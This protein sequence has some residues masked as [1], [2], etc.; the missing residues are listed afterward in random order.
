VGGV[1]AKK[2]DN[3]KVRFF[4]IFPPA[5]TSFQGQVGIVYRGKEDVMW[6]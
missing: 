1:G 6:E 5:A 4:T 3:K 2:D